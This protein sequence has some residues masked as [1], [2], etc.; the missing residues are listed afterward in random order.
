[1]TVNDIVDKSSHLIISIPKTNTNIERTFVV[2]NPYREIINNY[3]QKRPNIDINKLFFNYKNGKCTKQTVGINKIGS[4]PQ[5]I[6]EFLGLEEP[7]LYTGHSFRRT[8]AT[9]LANT[10]A[11][12]TS[13]KRHGGWK[14]A[15]V[16]EG[17]VESSIN[18][19]RKICKKITDSIATTNDSSSSES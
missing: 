14:S 7:K 12:I 19:K 10:G 4:Y 5:N 6:S 8:S 16:A 17:Y 18:N 15:Q 3:I 2:E 11:S 13:L 9:L 1:M